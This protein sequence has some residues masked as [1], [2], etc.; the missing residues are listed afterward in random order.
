MSQESSKEIEMD[1]NSQDSVSVLKQLTQSQMQLLKKMDD[2]QSS[3]NDNTDEMKQ[4]RKQNLMLSNT[5]EDGYLHAHRA[6]QERNELYQFSEKLIVDTFMTFIY[7]LQQT[8]KHEP[9]IAMEFDDFVTNLS[10][11]LQEDHKGSPI[12]DFILRLS[13]KIEDKYAELQSETD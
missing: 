9:E 1:L 3:I 8:F 13:R 6:N 12:Y 2:C 7:K 5:K 11:D 4:L 10:S